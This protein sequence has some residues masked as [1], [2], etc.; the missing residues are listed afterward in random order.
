MVAMKVYAKQPAI[1]PHPFH[2]PKAPLPSRRLFNRWL[3]GLG[4][5]LGV[6]IA[7]TLLFFF[8]KPTVVVVT[9]ISGATVYFNGEPRGATNQLNRFSI[10]GVSPGRHTVRLT[11]PEYLDAEQTVTVSH[12]FFAIKVNLPLRPSQ[13]DLTVQTEPMTTVTLD[14]LQIGETDVQT[15]LLT[16]PRVRVGSHFL[17]LRRTGYLPLSAVVEMPEGN[18]RL[19][20]PLQRDLSGYWKGVFQDATGKATDFVLNLTQTGATLS[21]LWEEAPPT[22]HRPPKTSLI[23]GQV[24][25]NQ[26][27]TLKRQ[28]NGRTLTLEAQ[29]A[30][31][32]RDLVGTWQDGRRTGSW[33][34]SHTDTKPTLLPPVPLPSL[35]EPGPRLTGAAPPPDL[36]PPDA[37]SPLAYAQKL[38]EQR[39]YNEA[40]AQCDTVLKQDPTNAAARDLKRRIQTSI[41][42]LTSPPTV[43]KP[44]PPP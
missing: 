23:T 3:Y 13:F 9:N 18:H 37:A 19:T 17:S 39:R 16:I 22:P 6:I 41:E 15:G 44:P 8:S 34:S 2:P 36:L 26:R 31:G 14:G 35:P 30:T 1:T 21:G 42:I 5:C 24:L 27:L 29:I 11:H 25:D 40:L 32:G 33:Q 28:D 4:A 38:Y 43:T 10:P 20:L 7:G 12:S